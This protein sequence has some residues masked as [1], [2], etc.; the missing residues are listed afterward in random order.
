[1][2]RRGSKKSGGARG[3]VI[4]RTRFGPEVIAAIQAAREGGAA[5]RFD[6]DD[7]MSDPRL[8]RAAIIDGI[9]SDR[10]DERAVREFFSAI[11]DTINSSD[12]CCCPTEELALH[13]RW[14]ERIV[15][16]LPNGFSH[17]MLDTSR[18]LVRTRHAAARDHLI[19][20]GYAAGTHTHQKDFSHAA[21][22]LTPAA[23]GAARLPPSVVPAPE[24]W[25]N[26]G[27]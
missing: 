15:H 18:V 9:R 14:K 10:H 27:P 5:V 4:W 3:F 26:A 22:A 6:L 23:T 24:V 17:A 20:I 12:S 25:P 13:L 11:R 21:A 8:A 1:M 2:C 19:R 7:L 16:V